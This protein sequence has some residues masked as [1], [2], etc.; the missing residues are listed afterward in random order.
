MYQGKDMDSP[1]VNKAIF[2]EYYDSRYDV[3]SVER[4]LYISEKICCLTYD[5]GYR[6]PSTKSHGVISQKTT[7][8]TLTACQ[9][10]CINKDKGLC[11]TG[12][13]PQNP[14]RFK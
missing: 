8:F 4:L 9:H 1:F 2:V 7:S 11:I 6:S 10:E 5:G 12:F 14:A 13:L 3:Y